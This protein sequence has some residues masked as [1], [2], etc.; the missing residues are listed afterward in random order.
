MKY[1]D[2]PAVLLT[3]TVSCYWFGVGCM[4]VR[5]RRRSSD[6]AGLVP[7]QPLE[8]AMWVVWVPLVIAWIVLPWLALRHTHPWLAV[9]A[10]AKDD[11]AYAAARWLAAATALACLAM[12]AWCWVRMGKDWRMDV[13][14]KRKGTLITDGLFGWVRHPIYTLQMLLMLCSAIILATPPMLIIAG[15]HMLLVNLKARNEERHLLATHGES[16]A[17]Y[18]QRTGRFFPRLGAHGP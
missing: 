2:L 8:R 12:T 9:P 3:L 11:A 14:E 1:S 13:S 6:L 17:L 15:V 5:A 7:E 4:I 16:Y 18:L 10:F